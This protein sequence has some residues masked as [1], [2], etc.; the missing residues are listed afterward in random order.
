[1]TEFEK[2]QES[3]NAAILLIDQ[4]WSKN[5]SLSNKSRIV[6]ESVGKVYSNY[7]FENVHDTAVQK[8]IQDLVNLTNEVNNA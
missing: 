5:A 6:I 4:L 3:A 2:L 1:M 8:S 7:N